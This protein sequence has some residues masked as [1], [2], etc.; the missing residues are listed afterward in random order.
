VGGKWT[1]WRALSEQAADRCLAIMRR[2]RI[3]ETSRLAIGGGRD[4]PSDAASVRQGISSLVAQFGVTQERGRQL[5]ER[6]GTRAAAVAYYIGEEPDIALQSNPDYSRREI[7]YIAVR[8]KVVHLDDFLLRRSMLAMLGKTTRAT[9]EEVAST[10][11]GVL[12]WERDRVAAEI[13]RCE[14]I[15]RD[16]HQVRL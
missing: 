5:F 3:T 11:G 14:E 9:L 7:E 13:A 15:L 6:Y 4:Y 10:L 1:S 2:A 12:Y 8:E 16:K